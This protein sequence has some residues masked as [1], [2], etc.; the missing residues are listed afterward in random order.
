MQPLKRLVQFYLGGK[1]GQGNQMFSWIH[2][3][4]VYRII[5]FLMEHEDL[6]GVFNC[7]SPE[8][9]TNE[10]FM[11]TLRHTLNKKIGLP[12]P[13]WLLKMGAVV[14]R[15]ETELILKSRWVVPHRLLKS[16]YTFT[17]PSLQKAFEEILD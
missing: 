11:K 2:I 1:Q 17:C 4:D 13:E 12:S 7:S 5:M 10:I 8:P 6:S 15:T 14:I 9:V 3:E 16:G